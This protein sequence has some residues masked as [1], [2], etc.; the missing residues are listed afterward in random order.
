V[1]LYGDDLVE[2]Q[3]QAE[4]VEEVIAGVPGVADL[5]IVKSGEVPQIRC[6][7]SR[8]ARPLRHERSAT[9]ST[10]SRPPSA[11]ARSPRSGRASAA[12]T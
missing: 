11:A 1:K 10:S 8:R 3:A 6:A 4:K 2:L 5:G 9:S 7:G 12:S